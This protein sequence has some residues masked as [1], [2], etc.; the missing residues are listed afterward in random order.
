VADHLG[1]TR[2]YRYE[3]PFQ[4]TLD[5]HRTKPN[6]SDFGEREMRRWWRED[7]R[8]AGVEETIIGPE[9]SLA[10]TAAEIIADCGWASPLPNGAP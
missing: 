2:R 10:D 8:L 5:R 1:I 3:I 9:R 4:E 7:D 6:A